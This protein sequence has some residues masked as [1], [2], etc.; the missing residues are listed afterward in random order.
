MD[1]KYKISVIIPAYNVEKYIYSCMESIVNQTYQ[2]LEII[3]VDDGST[4]N[5]PALCDSLAQ[6]D[7][8]ITVIHKKNGGASS[9]RNAGLEVSTGDYIA[10]IDADDYIDLDMYEIMLSQIIEYNADA[11]ACGM[12]RESDDGLKEIWGS[13]DAE[14]E[15]F[16]RVSLLQK[17]GEANGILPV[18]PCNKLFKK[19]IVKNIRFDIR[20]QYAEDVLFN[21]LAAEHIEKMVSQNIPRYHYVNNAASTSHKVFDNNR[22]DEHRV[23]D[24]IFERVKDSP[25]IYPY[26]VK[27]DVLKAFRTIKEMCSSGNELDMF[28]QI[29]KRIVTHRAF[30]FQSS[31]FSK[32]AKIKT[33]FLW[34]LP[35]LYKIFIKY[36]AGR[37][38]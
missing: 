28:K 31:I 1:K 35:N 5:T 26:C 7:S 22:F 37:H 32:Q 29:R 33:L 36:Y 3:L 8:R 11:A 38:S 27:G 13:Y 15:E 21:F 20:F 24:I 25:E 16:D 17:V 2:N 30:I 10:F 9:A 6:R 23:M 19:E 34:L 4:D 14:I 18:S 12:I